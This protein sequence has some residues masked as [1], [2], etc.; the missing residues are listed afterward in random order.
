[1][2]CDSL[3]FDRNMSQVA[4]ESHDFS[5]GSMSTVVVMFSNTGNNNVA[6]IALNET[7]YNIL[8]EEDKRLKLVAEVPIEDLT[9]VSRLK[10][11]YCNK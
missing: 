10:L 1:M 3:R 7:D 5:R 9:Q 2:G 6:G 8:L 11:E 4:I